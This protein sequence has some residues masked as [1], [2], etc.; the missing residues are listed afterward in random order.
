MHS[1][2]DKLRTSVSD[3]TIRLAACRAAEAASQTLL[4]HAL[5]TVMRLHRDC[6]EVER[7]YSSR[8][9]AYP[10]GGRKAK[11]DTPWSAHVLTAGQVFHGATAEDIRWA[12]DDHDRILGLGLECVINVPLRGRGQV[13]GTV[14]FLAG[15][16]ALRAE[17]I[18]VA[19]A[20]GA[21]LAPALCEPPP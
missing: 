2:L 18:P 13:I 12:F 9:E 11:K 5:F 14:N 21:L 8:P 15:P 3:E 4:G 17:H 19:E 7:L 1:P 10:P 20:I 16:G 6:M